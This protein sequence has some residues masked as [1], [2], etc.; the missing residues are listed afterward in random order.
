[1]GAAEPIEPGVAP[2]NSAAPDNSQH[3]S[4]SASATSSAAAEPAE[5][6]ID[7]G[8]GVGHGNAQHASNLAA[9][10]APVAAELTAPGIAALHSNSEHPSDSASSSVMGAA[11]PIEPGVAPGNKHSA[12]ANASAAAQPRGPAPATGDED[13]AFAFHFKNHSGPFT[14]T[15]TV[16]LEELNSAP[17][18]LGQGAELAA[19]LEVDPAAMHEHA[20]SQVDNLQHHAKGHLS[21]ELLA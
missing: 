13:S 21:H 5:P 16:E 6:G 11:E 18:P 1:M 10:M 14:P 7:P 2:G 15:T 3:G 4:R 17:L 20:A 12:A 9:A 8:N 19:I